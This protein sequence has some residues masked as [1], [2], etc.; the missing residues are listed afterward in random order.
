M[1]KTI[2]LSDIRRWPVETVRQYHTGMVDVIRTSMRMHAPALFQAAIAQVR[3]HQPVHTGE[4]K[5]SGKVANITDGAMFYNPTVQASIIDHGR[6]PGRGVSREGQEALARWVHLHGMDREDKVS[7]RERRIR[8]AAGATGARFRRSWR[9]ENR[10]RAIAFLIARAIKRR[11]LPAKNVISGM[12]VELTKRVL[13]DVDAM[14][15]RG[16]NP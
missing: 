8:R 3:P 9:Q 5:R 13:A 14:V 11:G 12:E 4:Y 7:R 16:P 2:N 6:R 1:A 15:A 10:A